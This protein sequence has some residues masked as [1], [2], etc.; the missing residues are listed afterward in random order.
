[1]GDDTLNGGAGDDT[2]SVSAYSN[3][4][5][6][7][8]TGNDD[9]SVYSGYT[10]VGIV[11]TLDSTTTNGTI[12][13]GNYQIS[14]QNI[15][16]LEITGTFNSDSLLGGNGNDSLNG[17]GGGD[18]IKGGAG[19]DTLSVEFSEYSN[20][21]LLIG[22]DGNDVLTGDS[23]NSISVDTFAYNN[24]TEG[25]DTINKF[26]SSQDLIQV[27]ANG[28]GG[29]L[30]AGSL[31]QSQ[32]VLGTAATTSDQRFVYD[33]TTGALYFDLDG[34]GSGF[35]QRQLATITGGVSLSASNFTIV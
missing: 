18:T 3:S 23:I 22:G 15:E 17:Y 9:L 20:D 12:T 13:S 24:Y 19:D 26:D 34:S 21:N 27:S 33:N 16:R 2:L 30:I 35:T 14:F 31:S 4:L 25:V 6:D 7:G 10:Q 32:F 28:F 8:G 29:G 5:V 11:T 1:M